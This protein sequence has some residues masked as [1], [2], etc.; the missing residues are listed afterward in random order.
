MKFLPSGFRHNP[1]T[2]R[3]LNAR[4]CVIGLGVTGFAVLRFLLRYSKAALVTAYIGEYSERNSQ[5]IRNLFEEFFADE[6]HLQVFED[7]SH[8]KS[9]ATGAFG[10]SELLFSH[11]TSDSDSLE[12]RIPDLRICQNVDA[13]D[14][15]FE[16]G[17]ISP[18]IKPSSPLYI[19]AEEHTGELISEPELA[20]RFS[21]AHWLAVTGTNG[22]TTTTTLLAH[23]L[24]VAGIKARVAGNI[25]PT[26]IDAIQERD[27]DEYLVAELSSFQLSSSPHLCPEAAILLNITPDH[28]SWHGSFE[29]YAR[30]KT[31]VYA[32]MKSDQLVVIEDISPLTAGLIRQA[33]SAGHRILHLGTAPASGEEAAWVDERRSQQTVVPAIQDFGSDAVSAADH[34]VLK[35]TKLHLRLRAASQQFIDTELLDINELQIKGFH[36]VLNSLA[37]SA[38]AAYLGAD[39]DS[40][41]RGLRSFEAIEHRI[42][43]VAV[44]D[45]IEYYNDSKAT[46]PEATIMALSAFADKPLILLVGGEDKGTDLSDL[47]A[48]ARLLCKAVLCY[49]KAGSRF[50]EAFVKPECECP[51]SLAK[52][53]S[54]HL[55]ISDSGNSEYP[56][57]A[58]C[59][60]GHQADVEYFASGGMRAAFIRAQEL[61]AVGDVILLSPACASFDEFSSFEER[62]RVFKQWVA[63][64]AVASGVVGDAGNVVA[65]GAK[66]GIQAVDRSLSPAAATLQTATTA[67]ATASATQSI[68]ATI[69]KAVGK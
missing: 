28:L 69:S 30:V 22:K 54:G 41:R 44:V 58:T 53:A 10:N 42:E 67:T 25:G 52:Q 48:R 61:A 47:T 35:D 2:E 38:V 27:A 68:A 11:K 14:E 63:E 56:G 20:F 21:P 43:P 57:Q 37:A 33:E 31:L 39:V 15:D 12:E 55:L 46:N 24:R 36:N 32:E 49:G 7:S 17:V 59:E 6:G 29:E 50:F 1:E 62:G 65:G 8:A 34:E 9:L 64:A 5:A 51:G 18:G 3:I 45:A 23:L 26:L 4:I 13:L 60:G 19:S 40:I 66:A 16:I